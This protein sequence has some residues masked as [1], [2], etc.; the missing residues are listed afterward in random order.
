MPHRIHD[1]ATRKYGLETSDLIFDPLTF[2]LSTGGDD[3]RGDA[4]ETLDALRRI[5]AEL[6]GAHTVLGVSNVSFG[7]KSAVR[8]VLNSVF[9]HEAHEAGLDAAIAHSA[10]ILPLNRVPEDQRRICADLIYD[11]RAD[12]YDPLASLLAAFEDVGGH[13]PGARGPQ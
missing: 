2:P 8:Q 9:L 10:R 11:Q 6:P 13:R 7:L 5:K 4:M 3:L 1:L 12:G